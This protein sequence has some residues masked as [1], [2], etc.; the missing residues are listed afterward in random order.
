MHPG[1]F[2]PKTSER[3]G[4]KHRA[5]PLPDAPGLNRVPSRLELLRHQALEVTHTATQQ[6]VTLDNFNTILNSNSVNKI[7]C[8]IIDNIIYAV[9]R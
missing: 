8:L 4:G 9:R 1:S 6:P 5:S 3:P 7:V 2:G